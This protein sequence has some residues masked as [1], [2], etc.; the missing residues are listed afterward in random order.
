MSNKRPTKAELRKQ[1]EQDIAAYAEHGG[2]I[3]HVP[4]GESALVNGY[5]DE[6]RRPLEQQQQT[7]TPV[8]DVLKTIDERKQSKKKS[9]RP[10]AGTRSSKT[11]AK[12]RVIY[13]DFGEPLRVVWEE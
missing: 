7:R 9:Q 8:D 1:L 13:D 6:R 3:K 12:K 5:L 2:D 11:R 4:K 10:Q